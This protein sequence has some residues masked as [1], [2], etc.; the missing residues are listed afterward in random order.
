M[1]P[2]M[3]KRALAARDAHI[4]LL[5]LKRVVDEATRSTHAVE[6]EA[7]HLAISPRP[8]GDISSPLHEILECLRSTNFEQILNKARQSL[9]AAMS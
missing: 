5:D 1:N 4:A 9:Q 2:E 8:G 6:L 3:Q 7:V